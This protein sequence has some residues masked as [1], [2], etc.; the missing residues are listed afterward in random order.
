MSEPSAPLA[1]VLL[2]ED[3]ASIRRFVALALEDE[4]LELVQSPGLASARE[5]LAA[6][7]RFDLVI[8]DLMLGDGNGLALLQELSTSGGPARLAFSAGIDRNMRAR[9][10]ELGV[11]EVL[12]KPVSVL[13]LQQAVARA[14]RGR[15]APAAAPPQA[16][17]DGGDAAADGAAAQRY[18]GGDQALFRAYRE[19]CLAQFEQDLQ[20]G[21]RFIAHGQISD[22]RHLA[23]SLKSVLL[24]LGEASGSSQARALEEHAAAGDMAAAAAR[25]PPLRALLQALRS[26]AAAAP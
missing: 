16:A 17:P 2:V 12:S 23:H 5:L 6:G 8:A 7:P 22:L 24:M 9:L 11:D 19:Q 10:A 15:H 3:D 26:R 4:P 1:R 20:H 14:L 13:A 21:E 18:F 25:W